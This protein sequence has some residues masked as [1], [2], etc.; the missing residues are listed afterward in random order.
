MAVEFEAYAVYVSSF[1]E[2][3]QCLARDQALR[4]EIAKCESM[5]SNEYPLAVLLSI[6]LNH[7]NEYVLLLENM[8]ALVPRRGRAF[9]I[10]GD[11]LAII[12]QT[13]RF[14][15]EKSALAEQQAVVRA[16]RRRVPGKETLALASPNRKYHRKNRLA[17]ETSTS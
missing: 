2:A 16:I 10:I 8:L 14:I 13:H 7:I 3:V 1:V 6:P 5:S 4:D 11:A 17:R 15:E 9:G 12:Y